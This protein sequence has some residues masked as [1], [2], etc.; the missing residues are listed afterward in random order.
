[1]HYL[2]MKVSIPGDMDTSYGYDLAYKVAGLAA[3]VRAGDGQAR[4]PRAES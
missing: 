4:A 3:P 2:F 1:M